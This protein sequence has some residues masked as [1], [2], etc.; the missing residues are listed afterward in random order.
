M[1]KITVSVQNT[2]PDTSLVGCYLLFQC[3]DAMYRINRK[4]SKVRVEYSF[5]SSTDGYKLCFSC[6]CWFHPF[7][8]P[9]LT[10]P[11]V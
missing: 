9:F 6:L 3:D 1:F 11:S 4:M 10:W 8:I 7:A 5:S 2:S